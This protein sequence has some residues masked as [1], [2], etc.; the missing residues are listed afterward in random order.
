[1]YTFLFRD[2]TPSSLPGDII[3]FLIP[4]NTTRGSKNG[5]ICYVMLTQIKI[6]NSANRK[7]ASYQ[8]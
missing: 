5:M 8:F 1:M 3:P 2:I 7:F 6:L 4:R